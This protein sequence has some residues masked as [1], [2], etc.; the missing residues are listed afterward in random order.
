[1]Q[2]PIV[3]VA[4]VVIAYAT[5]TADGALIDVV[6]S[7]YDCYAKHRTHNY[8]LCIRNLVNVF[9]DYIM[10]FCNVYSMLNTINYRFKLLQPNM[11]S[12]RH[13]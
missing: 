8:N 6:V 3:A 5:T 4:A 10:L 11:L 2:V 7:S 13:N 12:T 9:T 1:M